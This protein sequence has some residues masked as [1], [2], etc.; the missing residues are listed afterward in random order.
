MKTPSTSIFDQAH[1]DQRLLS[2]YYTAGYPDLKSTI[3]VAIALQEAG[4]DFLEIGIPYSDPIADGPVIQQSSMAALK[5]GM[6]VA[7]LFLQLEQLRPQVGIPVFL[8]G[9]INPILQYGVE[10]FLQ[11]C[12]RVGVNGVII[13]DLPLKE[14]E[15]LYKHL[16]EAY[17]IPLVF[18][19]TPQTSE[20]R[21]R[22]IDS[23][24]RAF[25]YVLSSPSV[26]GK[27]LDL[28][29]ETTAYFSRIKAMNLKTPTIIGFGISGEETFMHATNYAAGAIVGTAYVKLLGKENPLEN[30]AGFIKSIRPIKP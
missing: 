3:P 8:M 5:N 17:D 22:K 1:T 16:F 23:L 7:E 27:K 10:N 14:Y 12:Q 6:T 28:T 30:T 26:T 21:I 19:I 2:V 11:A 18:M 13:P 25:I 29:D 15:T 20:E 4:V 24:S 9:Y